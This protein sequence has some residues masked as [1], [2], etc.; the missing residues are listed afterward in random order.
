MELSRAQRK[1]LTRERIL[2]AALLL[3][4]QG[5]G[6]DSLGL[7][8]LAREAGLAATS[9][10]NHFANMD[11]LGMALVERACYRLRTRMGEG[12]RALI[13]GDAEA[14]ISAMI[15]K[16]LAYLGDHEAEFRLLVRQ[17]LGHSALYRRRIH[18]ELQMLVEELAAD[19]KV[20]VSRRLDL[21]VDVLREAEAAVAVM[22]GFGILALDVPA[23][24]RRRRLPDLQIQL[25]MIFL[26]GRA[27][28]AGGKLD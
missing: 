4:E 20:V 14:A 15:E 3:L 23:N 2:D 12:R 8:E 7:R 24:Q 13:E 19:V 18:R 26:G 11:E 16:F 6:L 21:P 25:R 10:Y 28:A 5:R 1:A 22:F 17:R 9:L 27:L